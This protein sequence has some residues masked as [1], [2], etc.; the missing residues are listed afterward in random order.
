MIQP[1]QGSLATIVWEKIVD[2]FQAKFAVV[3]A[4][5]KKVSLVP[6]RATLIKVSIKQA[7]P[8]LLCLCCTSRLT[9]IK[10]QKNGKSSMELVNAG[11]I[12]S[13]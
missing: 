11:A 6:P 1:E 2:K 12:C 3:Y 4:K 10:C 7:F 9:L 13:Y 8:S 5:S